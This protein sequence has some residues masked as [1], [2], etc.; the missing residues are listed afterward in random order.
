MAKKVNIRVLKESLWTVLDGGDC[1]Q[2]PAARAPSSTPQSFKASMSTLARTAPPE[3]LRDVSVAYC[4][5]CLLHLANE[6]GLKVEG[7]ADL[8]DLTVSKPTAARA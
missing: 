8:S 3:A 7:T 1:A 6:K 4:F 2:P 5:I